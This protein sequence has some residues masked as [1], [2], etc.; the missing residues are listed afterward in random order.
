MKKSSIIYIVILVVLV[1]LIVTAGIMK[2]KP[3][4]WTPTYATKDKIPLGLYIFDQEAP[5]LFK[6][7]TF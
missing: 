4:N 3:V 6:G 5:K 2:P 7:D 1:I